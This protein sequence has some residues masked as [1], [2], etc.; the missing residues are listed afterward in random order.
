VES[1][2]PGGVALL[3]SANLVQGSISP[4]PLQP[5]CRT[6]AADIAGGK[7]LE[8]RDDGISDGAHEPWALLAFAQGTYLVRLVPRRKGQSPKYHPRP[9]G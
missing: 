8:G 4:Q 6:D 9:G 3:C 1:L 5:A 2:S 7:G